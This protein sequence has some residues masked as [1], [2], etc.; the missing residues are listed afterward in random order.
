MTTPDPTMPTEL[1][2]AL[3]IASADLGKPCPP[4]PGV[5][6]F[7]EL[8]LFTDEE[9]DQLHAM[10]DLIRQYVA[11]PDPR[12]PLC[13][14][15]FGPPG[16]GK[17]FAVEQILNELNLTLT[18]VNLTQVSDAND[19]GEVLARA[20]NPAGSRS[21]P[22]GIVPTLRRLLGSNG[23]SSAASTGASKV[24]V[25]FF[26]EFDAPRDGAPYGWLAWFLAPM[27]DGKFLYNGDVITLRRAVYVFAGGT[28]LTMRQFS[29]FGPQR[30]F[31]RAKGPDFISRLR[32]FLDV[33][34]PNAE[35]RMLRRATLL[36]AE[37]TRAIG[38]RAGGFSVDSE[39]MTSL[40]QVGRYRHGARSISA[41]VELSHLENK[42]RFAWEDLPKDHLLGLHIDRGPLDAKLIRGSIAFSGYDEKAEVKDVWCKVARALWNEGATLSYAGRWASGPR[43][44]LMKFLEDELRMRP[45]EP[46]AD[47]GRRGK[48]DPWLESFLDDIE[49][50]HNS[51]DAAISPS[52]RDRMGVKVGFAPFL[53]MDERTH[54]DRW[55]CSQ[56]EHFRR[57]LAVTDASVARFVV[58]GARSDHYGRFPGI[59]EEVMLTLAQ[60]KPVYIA[61]AFGGT[62]ADIGSLLGLAHPQLG[63]VPLSLQ[64]DPKEAEASL[65]TIED[66]LQPAPWTELPVTAA[67]I[68]P[69][70]KAHALGGPD[71]PDNALTFDENRRLF[72]SDDPDEVTS[73]VLTGLLRLFA[74]ADPVTPDL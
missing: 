11:R 30:D 38:K 69:F 32:G 71:W 25:I 14:A 9:R 57:R 6:K 56:L 4:I 60:G 70:L 50:E 43:G 73:L 65:A 35:P 41:V 17:S 2:H 59:P 18:T 42:A 49:H 24:P 37:L 33:R 58:A 51:V 20:A 26:D 7:G 66:K 61:G 29:D 28:A 27:Q 72:V 44:W 1:S 55:Q 64:A 21:E 46:S 67:Q 36:R 19:L 54:L 5:N 10:H 63:E 15:V 12:R 34:G 40:L 68:V 52:D 39:L 16:S 13:L 31:Q 48:P 23:G 74:K 22:S 8:F 45:A 3:A 62:A 53:T 47:P